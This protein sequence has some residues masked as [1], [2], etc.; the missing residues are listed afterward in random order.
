MIYCS[1]SLP[2]YQDL[3]RPADGVYLK[4]EFLVWKLSH[5]WKKYNMV[6]FHHTEGTL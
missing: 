4:S 3:G 6:T 1:G 5:G 2:A